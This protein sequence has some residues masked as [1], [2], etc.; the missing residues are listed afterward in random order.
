MLHIVFKTSAQEP[1][2]RDCL[3]SL[4]PGDAL[5]VLNEAVSELNEQTALALSIQEQV[6]RGC[7]IMALHEQVSGNEYQLLST[8]ELISYDV[9]VQLV[10]EHEHSRSWF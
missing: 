6:Q 7:R 4:A 2:L 8:V 9:F 10:A 5:I 1:L 3:D